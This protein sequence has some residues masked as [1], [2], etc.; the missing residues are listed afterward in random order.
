M[1][2]IVAKD[3]PNMNEKQLRE[4][5]SHDFKATKAKYVE[6][7][8]KN[9]AKRSSRRRINDKPDKLDF[10]EFKFIIEQKYEML[11][12]SSVPV[13]PHDNLSINL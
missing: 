1:R 11:S 10:E 5:I 13:S 8:K 12:S 7:L 4:V 6:H 9:L 2:E 3:L